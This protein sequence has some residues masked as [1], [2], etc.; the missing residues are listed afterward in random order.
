MHYLKLKSYADVLNSQMYGYHQRSASY[1]NEVTNA[2]SLTESAKRS[3]EH[4]PMDEM[5]GITDN[6]PVSPN[7]NVMI[8][9]AIAWD[10]WDKAP[11]HNLS[12]QASKVTATTKHS[13]VTLSTVMSHVT[14]L[15]DEMTK[16]MTQVS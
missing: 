7:E 12:P 3:V 14:H 4:E 5:I 15:Q 11:P 13:E 16:V 8:P 10:E 9:T 1:D 6:H 2:E